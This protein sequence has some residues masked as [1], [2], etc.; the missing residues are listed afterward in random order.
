M[1]LSRNAVVT[2]RQILQKIFNVNVVR[3]YSSLRFLLQ[4]TQYTV[5]WIIKNWIELNWTSIE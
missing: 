2:R 4:I 5:Q 1:F 3:Y